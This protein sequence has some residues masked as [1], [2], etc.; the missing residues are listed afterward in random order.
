LLDLSSPWPTAPTLEADAREALDAFID[1]CLPFCGYISPARIN[2]LFD[3]YATARSG[4]APDRAALVESCLATGY[5]RLR[6][7]GRSGRTA[8]RVEEEAR[9]DVRWFRACVRTLEEWGSASFTAIR[10]LIETRRPTGHAQ[11]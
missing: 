2:D 3:R 10:K 8:Q 11:A 9:T 5:V 7:F 6:Y 1:Y 4:L